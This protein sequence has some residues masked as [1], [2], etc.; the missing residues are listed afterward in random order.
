MNQC[1]RQWVEQLSVIDDD[2]VALL[3]QSLMG[4]GE[5]RGGPMC[6]VNSHRPR[7]GPE[8][9]GTTR[10]SAQHKPHRPSTGL[11]SLGEG[12]SQ[13][14]FANA[15]VTDQRDAVTLRGAVECR[16]R[17][18]KLVVASHYRPL[19]LALGLHRTSDPP[20]PPLLRPPFPQNAL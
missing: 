5:H 11:D 9:H 3:L 13:C 6:C 16:Q 17:A 7:E 1:G 2:E 18:T 12:A 4:G 20:G 10:L 8:W 19:R 15:A 14:R